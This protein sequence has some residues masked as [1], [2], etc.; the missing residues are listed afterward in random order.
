MNPKLRD[1]AEHAGVSVRTVSNVVNDFR[2]VAPST[3]ERVQ[4]SIDALGYRPN[5]AAR[6][7]RRG[8]TGLVALVVPEIDSPYY[9]ELAARTV[10]IAEARGLTVLI[11]QTDGDAE[12]ETQLLHGKR[13][14]LVDGVLFSPWAVAPAELAARTDTVPLVLLGEH[15]GPAGV[16]HVVIDNVAAAHEATAHLLA[17]GRRR[18]AAMGIQPWSLNATARQRLAGYRTALAGAGLPA[19]PDLEVP[20]RHLHRADGHEAMLRLLDSPR[21]PDAVFCF[22]D[23]LALGA[24]RAAADRGVAVPGSLALVGFDDV[25][26]GRFSVPALT[27][28]SP[29][30]SRIAELALDLLTDRTVA[31]RPPRSVIA[32]HRLVVRETS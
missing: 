26:D 17:R 4:A 1:V 2:Y 6:T 25:E 15:D 30:K 19:D 29:D 11:D 9:A 16:D 8:R 28:V 32:P 10:R 23:E 31:P 5:M 7:L 20:V 13:S 14:Q 24:L 12:R 27:T 21:P 22:T 18:I 3:R